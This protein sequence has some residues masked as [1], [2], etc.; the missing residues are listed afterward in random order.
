MSRSVGGENS[1]LSMRGMENASN[2][3]K[4]AFLTVVG[5]SSRFPLVVLKVADS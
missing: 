4:A 2:N 5:L 1:G 3:G